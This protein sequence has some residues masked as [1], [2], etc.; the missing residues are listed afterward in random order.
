[1][2]ICHLESLIKVHSHLKMS[3]TH[4]FFLLTEVFLTSS[5]RFSFLSRKKINNSAAQSFSTII[6]F[7]AMV[8][9]KNYFHCPFSS[10]ARSILHPILG[11]YWSVY[12]HKKF[13][14]FL[15]TGFIQNRPL[16]KVALHLVVTSLSSINND[17][18]FIVSS[19]SQVCVGLVSD[20]HRSFLYSLISTF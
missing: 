17:A 2:H 3:L 16:F 9:F 14:S 1:M 18:I 4:F 20:I 7:Q 11:N 13:A 12:L 8:N 19:E 10:L 15:Q 5:I 6:N